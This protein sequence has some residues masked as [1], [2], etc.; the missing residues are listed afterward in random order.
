METATISPSPPS[1]ARRRLRWWL[2]AGI[3]VIGAGLV[4]VVRVYA[5]GATGILNC[6]D[7]GTGKVIWSRDILADNN[8]KNLQWAKSCS[9]LVFDDIVVVTLGDAAEPS[10][11]AYTGDS[12]RPLWRAG[13]DKPSY[14]TPVLATLADREQILVVNAG[15]VSSHDP[16]VGDMLWEYAW[17]GEMAL[18]SVP[19]GVAVALAAA[20]FAA[21]MSESTIDYGY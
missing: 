21:S 17:P 6:L 5:M 16:S 1:P 15:S 12:G 9:P 14:A 18:V 19:A 3:L 13:H 8:Q 2:L 20:A 4:T 7:G 11:A 10:L